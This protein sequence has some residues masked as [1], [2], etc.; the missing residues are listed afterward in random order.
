M[1]F[2]RARKQVDGPPTYSADDNLPGDLCGR[3]RGISGRG[4]GGRNGSRVNCANAG[5][6]ASASGSS[7]AEAAAREEAAAAGADQARQ[8]A[9]TRQVRGVSARLHRCVLCSRLLPI[10]WFVQDGGP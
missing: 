5:G 9:A 2:T 8:W 3:E 4:G 1:Q 6:A 7:P 10:L